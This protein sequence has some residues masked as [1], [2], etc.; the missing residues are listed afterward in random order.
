M[1]YKVLL[2]SELGGES[3][4]ANARADS[5][6]RWEGQWFVFVLELVFEFVL[7]FEQLSL[8]NETK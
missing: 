3:E 6:M 1:A 7:E 2:E 8:C 5:L 4:D